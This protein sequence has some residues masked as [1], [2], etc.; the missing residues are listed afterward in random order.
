MSN[1]PSVIN[2]DPLNVALLKTAFAVMVA[3]R[4]YYLYDIYYPNLVIMP[5]DKMS[6]KGLITYLLTVY[7]TI[8]GQ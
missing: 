4:L 5:V 2:A 1:R 7:P 8:Y 6:I 3:T